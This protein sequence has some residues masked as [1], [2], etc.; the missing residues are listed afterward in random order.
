MFSYPL[1]EEEIRCFL[2]GDASTISLTDSLLQLCLRHQI[3]QTKE[4][5][6]LKD[7]PGLVKKRLKG[8]DRA[9]SRLLKAYRESRFLFKFPF[10]RGISISGSLSKNYSDEKGDIDYFII[11]ASG[12]LW[13]ARTLLHLFKKL[14]Y[15]YGAQHHY[16]MNYFV[17]EDALEIE[18]KN[19]FTAVETV[20]LLPLCGNG[21]QEKFF[22]SNNWTSYY[23]P[24]CGIAPEEKYYTGGKL[25]IKKIGETLLDNSFGNWLDTILLKITSRRWKRKER[26]HR[27]NMKGNPMSIVCKKHCCKPNPVYFQVDILKK[28]QQKLNELHLADALELYPE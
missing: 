16:C 23:L 15:L 20:T 11:T 13:I 18:E 27:L 4:F 19:I 2:S 25:R 1:S 12:K 8:N 28:Y 21:S 3:F 26:N 7:N 6:S 14:T 17:D 22:A 9:N 10:V 24:N 5:Y